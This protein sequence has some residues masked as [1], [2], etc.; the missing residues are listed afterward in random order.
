MPA[1]VKKSKTTSA[2]R[3]DAPPAPPDMQWMGLRVVV[4]QDLWEVWNGS[5][6]VGS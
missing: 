5:D 1:R 3:V 6:C 4:W 2:P